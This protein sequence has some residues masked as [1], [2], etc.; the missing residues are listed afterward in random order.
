MSWFEK[1]GEKKSVS[2]A[3]LPELP[4]LPELPSLDSFSFAN[5]PKQAIPNLPSYP[6]N[7]FGKKFSQNAIKDAVSGEKEDDNE[8]DEAD[9]FPEN[10]E[11]MPKPLQNVLIKKP[12]VYR[13]EY[14][15]RMPQFKPISKEPV[16]IRIDKFEE[17]LNMLSDAK[18]K[19]SEMEDMLR[20]I[21][22]IKE[23]E[24]NE[25]KDWEAEI[26]KIKS[27]F[28]KMDNEL[29]SRI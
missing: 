10:A 4:M 29:F 5:E 21:K 24:E 19:V 15:P 9:E 7:S 28:E 20:H 6:N 18:N 27:D 11:T 14:K 12:E 22:K 17:A 3:S 26:Q 16:Y 23:E 1:K 8:E 25:L 2:M 13:E